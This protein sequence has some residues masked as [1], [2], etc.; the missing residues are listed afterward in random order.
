MASYLELDAPLV[1]MQSGCISLLHV[2]KQ[3]SQKFCS[4]D[5]TLSNFLSVINRDSNNLATCVVTAKRDPDAIAVARN[6][7]EVFPQ[8]D[9]VEELGCIHSY[10]QASTNFLVFRR[11]FVHIYHHTAVLGTVMVDRERSTKAANATTNDGD[12]EW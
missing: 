4:V 12:V 2:V 6:L 9:A 8:A 1:D 11:L 7:V 10:A 3:E 5:G